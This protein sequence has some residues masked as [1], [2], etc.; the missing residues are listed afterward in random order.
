MIVKTRNVFSEV[1][2][3]VLHEQ[4]VYDERAIDT[5]T[6]AMKI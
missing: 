3:L 1:P 2:L 4:L 5:S 6:V